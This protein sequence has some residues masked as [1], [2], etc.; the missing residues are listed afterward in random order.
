ML[1][2]PR[3]LAD[4]DFVRIEFTLEFQETFDLDLP[5]LLRL[6]RDLR[7][8]AQLALGEGDVFAHL[9]DP[10]L[11]ADPAALRR[12]QRPG[13]SFVIRP[14]P[15]LCTTYE[16]G[17]HL[18]LR[19]SFWGRGAQ[20]L[21]EFAATLKAL[22]GSGLNRGEGRF[23]LIAMQAFNLAGDMQW[24][25]KSGRPTGPS[26][27]PVFSASWWLDSL[28]VLGEH[29]TLEFVTPA[30]L[31]SRGRPLFRPD[32]SSLFPFILRR[33]TSMAYAHSGLELIDDPRPWQQAA[34]AVRV[35]VNELHW[36]D[37]RTLE[38]HGGPQDIGGIAGRLSLEGESLASMGWLLRL[39][40]LLQLGKGASYGAGCYVLT[41]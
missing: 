27:P 26:A 35:L 4:L 6:R 32:F 40:S 1:P 9:F 8:A 10:P 14:D 38:S 16:E 41:P 13:P 29:A 17:D 5:R 34:A 25:W 39:G 15:A 18:P 20:L 21:N 11:S 22:G 36:R 19:V 30:R 23:E 2:A 7:A 28:P 24:L 31:L 3:A 12:F 37:W 33:V